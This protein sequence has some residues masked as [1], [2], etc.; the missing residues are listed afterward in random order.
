[1][2]DFTVVRRSLFVRENFAHSL[3]HIGVAGVDLQELMPL[4]DI[5]ALK[6]VGFVSNLCWRKSGWR[7]RTGK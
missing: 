7:D 1:M 4:V 6:Q 5:S 3:G 2:K